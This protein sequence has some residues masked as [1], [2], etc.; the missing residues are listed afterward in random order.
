MKVAY[1]VSRFPHVSETFIVRELNGV[2]AAAD[3]ER[4][5]VL[6][7]SGRRSDGAPGGAAVGRPACD[8]ARRAGALR[9]WRG[10]CA[11]AA[12]A[13]ERRG[14]IVRAF[15][16]KPGVLARCARH[17]RGRQRPRAWPCGD[18][19]SSTCT[20]TSRRYPALA[21]WTVGAADRR[22][23]QLHRARAR[24]LRRP[25]VPAPASRATRASSWRSPTSTAASSSPTCRR[26]RSTS[27]T[28]ASTRPAGRTAARARLRR[29]PCAPCAS[30]ACR[31]TRATAVLLE[32][33]GPDGASSASSSTSS[34]GASCAPSSRRSR[35]S[36]GSPTAC[37]STARCR[38]PEVAALLDRADLFVLPSVVG[39]DGHMEGIPVALMEALAA[40][41]PV[42]STRLSGIPELVRDGETGLLAEPGDPVSLR[43]ASRALD[44]RARRRRDARAAAGRR[45]VEDEFDAAPRPRAW[46]SCSGL[47]SERSLAPAA[48][49]RAAA[50]TGADTPIERRRTPPP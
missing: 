47:S 14:A 12:R 50:A 7:L 13:A 38:A 32:A 24:H 19:A 25:V 34:A 30:L 41:V 26:R 35:A 18:S 4:R 39:A 37:A 11:G 15:A 43:A 22:R 20:P 45:L 49:V 8:A 27:C 44:Q 10:G 36:S 31:S 48:A 46:P 40:G 21:A 5:A 28:A 9:A 6:A 23:V 17:R 42:V 1:V 29:A 16:R 3:I 2:D 33:L